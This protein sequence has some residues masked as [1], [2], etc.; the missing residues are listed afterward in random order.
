MAKLAYLDVSAIVKFA[1]REAETAALE[2]YALE[3]DG[4][5]MSRLGAA[6]ARR[7]AR[8]VGSGARQ[9][10]DAFEAVYLYDVTSQVL[11]LA[12]R[13]DPL[14]LKTSDA[15][16]L[17][18]A[19]GIGEPDIEFVTYDGK[20]ARAAEANGLRMVQPGRPAATS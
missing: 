16:H 4:M 11:E 20:L 9:I 7:A 19:I 2:R 17:A 1:V 13:I 15:I 8:R 5:V 3:C 6:E 14:H 12:A 18:T 10:E